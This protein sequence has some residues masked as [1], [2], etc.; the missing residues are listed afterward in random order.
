[1]TP[2]KARLTEAE[3]KKNHIESEKKRREAI[4]Q[5][6]DKLCEIV[7]DMQGQARS[8]AIVLQATVEFMKQKVAEKERVTQ[9]AMQHGWSRQQIQNIYASA[10]NES[11]KRDADLEVAKEAAAHAGGMMGQSNG[12]ANGQTTPHQSPNA[13]PGRSG[14][15]NSQSRSP[16]G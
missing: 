3:K 4:R 7:P 11:R 16:T 12:R 10:E 5:G 6:F 2:A 9:L 13:A 14:G 15:S 1:M 8:E